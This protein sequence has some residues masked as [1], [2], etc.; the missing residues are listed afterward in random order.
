MGGTISPLARA[1]VRRRTAAQRTTPI[2]I[3][4]GATG[5]LDPDTGLKTGIVNPTTIYDGLARI[6][7]IA[8]QGDIAVG[9]AEIDTRQVIISIPWDA[10]PLPL[11][12]DIVVIGNDAIN[13]PDVAG[14]A[15]QV[16]EVDGGGIFGDARRLHCVGWHGNGYWS[17]S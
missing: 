6:H 12:H 13:D 10:T 3:L 2:I 17:G 11:Q 9:R 15:Y 1:L 8:G 5:P 4:R 16:R 7:P 14:E